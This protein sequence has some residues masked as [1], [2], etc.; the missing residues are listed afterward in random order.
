MTSLHAPEYDFAL[1]GFA[2][3]GNLEIDAE[4]VY[5]TYMLIYMSW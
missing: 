5:L 1:T 2:G 4:S 3:N